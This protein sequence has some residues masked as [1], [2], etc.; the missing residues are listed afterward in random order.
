MKKISHSQYLQLVGLQVLA[1]KH[2]RMMHDIEA[3]ACE[4]TGEDQAGHT[5]DILY[6]SRELDEG[7]KLM[8]IEVEPR[9]PAAET[10]PS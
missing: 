1:E 6:G 2:N 7:L 10:A 5:A 4:I 8:G 9:P 3:C